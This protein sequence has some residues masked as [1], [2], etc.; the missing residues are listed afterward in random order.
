MHTS[1][2]STL[3]QMI[4]ERIAGS[5]T[6]GNALSSVLHISQDAVYRRYRGETLLTIEEVRKI[7]KH[8]AISFDALIELSSNKVTFTYSPLETYDFSLESYL[9]GILNA[10]KQLKALKH[11]EIVISI[12]NTPLFQLL[13]F[14]QLV[15]FRLYFWAKTH[16]QMEAYKNKPFRH[17]KP[18]ETA[19]E[20]GREILQLYNSIPSK[21]I[22][23]FELMRGFMRQILY[24]FKGHFFEDPDYALF[25]CDR[26]SLLSNHLK[27][28]ANEGKKF[29]F[30]TQ[31]PANGNQF[32]MY[33]NETINT[34]STFLYKSD[35]HHGLFLTH[36]IMNY[37]QTTD[38]TYVTDTELILGKQLANSSIISVVNE[39]ERNHFFHEF[40]RT[41]GF[42]RKKIEAD[43]EI[44]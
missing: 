1:I 7:C 22:Y 26:V 29:I 6:I 9:S 32:E 37:L 36:N 17:E 21:E 2:Q 30:G 40:D 28:Q 23:D 39:K 12:N 15:R 27:E 44:Q 20:L 38:S 33:L 8:F 18:S 11:P 43:L 16:L 3:F 42:F 13:N 25:L 19:Y 14:P 34:D 5:D 4:K 41:I 24:Y 35:A 10:L 31:A